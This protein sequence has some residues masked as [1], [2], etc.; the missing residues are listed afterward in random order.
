MLKFRNSEKLLATNIEFSVEIL[1]DIVIIRTS[2]NSI[3]S[4]IPSEVYKNMTPRRMKLFK[5]YV[6][7]VICNP[8]RTIRLPGI[9]PPDYS[10]YIDLD[11]LTRNAYVF[12][13]AVLHKE[14]YGKLEQHLAQYG[15][16][17][18]FY[19]EKTDREVNLFDIAVETQ[20]TEK[21]VVKGTIDNILFTITWMSTGIRMLSNDDY[22]FY[23]D[24]MKSFPKE[25]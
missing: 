4:M 14:L 22:L 19:Y 5:G 3:E 24:A 12:A 2:N 1:T 21:P 25:L 13:K 11:M 18:P 23:S 15:L 9:V 20:P 6:Y 17:Y 16:S 8:D 10:D 7:D